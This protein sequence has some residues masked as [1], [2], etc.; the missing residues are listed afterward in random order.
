M[1]NRIE[2]LLSSNLSQNFTWIFSTPKDI[3][4]DPRVEFCCKLK[5][6]NYG[7]RC[8][9]PP[10][11][12]DLRIRAHQKKYVIIIARTVKYNNMP[13]IDN[14][15]KGNS[16]I[17]HFNQAYESYKIAE[18]KFKEDVLKIFQWWG[19]TQEDV[20]SLGF[21]LSSC[22][23]CFKKASNR[24]K[25]IKKQ[26]F[27]M[28]SISGLEIDIISTMK[29]YNYNMNFNLNEAMSRVAMIFTD[30]TDCASYENQ[31]ISKNNSIPPLERE[32]SPII[33]DILRKEL[34]NL[35]F[36]IM[37]PN[38]INN[39]LNPDYNYVKLWSSAIFWKLKNYRSKKE[40]ETTKQSVHRLIFNQ[41]FYFAIDLLVENVIKKQSNLSTY[42]AIEFF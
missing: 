7:R 30:N 41:G 22:D 13:E 42:Y 20:F 8:L 6:P 39:H 28:P 1:Q 33:E 18:S 19:L 10:Y 29:K 26:C 4:F 40:Y 25:G 14:K 24:K 31:I 12:S 21:P 34:P 11:V 15:F 38:L 23:L 9:C 17:L 35:E 32:S 16:S 3:I 36:I 37:N 2:M 5:C 27:P